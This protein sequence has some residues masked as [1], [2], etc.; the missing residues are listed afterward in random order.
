MSRWCRRAAA[1]ALLSL[2]TAVRIA[3]AAEAQSPAG[4][5]IDIRDLKSETR[6]LTFHIVSLD[7]SVTDVQTP[8]EVQVT[9]AADVFFA[10]DKADLTVPAAV[11][12]ADLA[13]R[14]GDQAKGTVRI[15]GYTDAKGTD[16]YNIDLSQRRAAAVQADLSRRLTGRNLNFEATGKG[17]TNF[18][19]PNTRPD[20]SDDPDGRAR[21]RRVTITYTR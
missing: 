14:I 19:A 6:D 15:E 11:A 10:F 4:L 8:R 20:G 12:L 5:K 3:P 17:A 21:N 13:P 1:L 9:L 18:V 16:A 2:A 7:G